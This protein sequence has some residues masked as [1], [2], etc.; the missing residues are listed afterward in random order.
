MLSNV[1]T[2]EQYIG[3]TVV[4]GR[5]YKKTLD[6]RWRQHLSR[7]KMESKDWEMCACLRSWPDPKF[8]SK[9]VLE[10]VR[11]RKAAHQRER[12]LIAEFGPSLNTF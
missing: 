6:L 9:E 1:I 10:V 11:G 5:A 7:A 2:G 3:I 8:W 12:I 4:R